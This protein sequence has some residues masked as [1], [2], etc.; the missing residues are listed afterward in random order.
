MKDNEWIGNYLIAE[1][2]VASW[3]LYKGMEA[4]TVYEVRKSKINGVGGVGYKTLAS[5]DTREEAKQYV[6]EQSYIDELNKTEA[7]KRD[8]AYK[9]KPRTYKTEL[10][11]PWGT[12]EIT[13]ALEECR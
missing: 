3:N 11:T 6:E 8:T 4:K 7:G 12:G 5:F 2:V 9:S 13:S 10:L 1:T